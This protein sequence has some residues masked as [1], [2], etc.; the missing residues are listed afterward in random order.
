MHE[1]KIGK[2]LRFENNVVSGMGLQ[3]LCLTVQPAK[4]CTYY[5]I[6]PFLMIIGLP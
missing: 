1:N 3:L 2:L 6:S 5:Y 4:N